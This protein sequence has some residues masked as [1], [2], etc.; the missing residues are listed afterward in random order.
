VIGDAEL[1][2]DQLRD[3]LAG[4]HIGAVT[5]LQRTLRQQLNQTP[6]LLGRQLSLA[7]GREAPAQGFLAALPPG[8]EPVHH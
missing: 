4:S 3:P 5:A 8:M 7:P 2:L 1:L 6:L